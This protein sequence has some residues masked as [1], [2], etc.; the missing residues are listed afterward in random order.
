MVLLP[1][2]WTIVFAAG[3]ALML[4][5]G[6]ATGKG[7]L[8]AFV[9]QLYNVAAALAMFGIAIKLAQGV[10]RRAHSGIGALGAAGP[11]P[12]GGRGLG[13]GARDPG[14]DR[15]DAA[16]PRHVLPGDPRAHGQRRRRGRASSHFPVRHPVRAAQAV[17]YP[18]RRPVQATREA[19]DGL[20]DALANA[21]TS[22]ASMADT[23]GSNAKRR[24]E[25][26]RHGG[27]FSARN[28]DQ[29]RETAT[30]ATRQ[31]TRGDARRDTRPAG[32]DPPQRRRPP[33][34]RALPSQPPAIAAVDP[35]GAR[36]VAT[37]GGRASRGRGAARRARAQGLR[38]TPGDPPVSLPL[39]PASA[40]AA[41]RSRPG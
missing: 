35:T 40:A 37:A 24:F 9:A 41:P 17:S 27:R 32:A 4:D 5:A 23:A 30:P 22:G 38:S 31:C 8:A 36:R 3:A 1:L 15:Q 26:E 19:A 29:R 13:G 16:E 20:R 11:L 18:A 39:T 6:T 34:R 25:H 7:G 10:M 12:G 2:L 33:S 21:R 28:A 14:A